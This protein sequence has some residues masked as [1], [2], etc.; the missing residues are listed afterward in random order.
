MMAALERQATGLLRWE[1]TAVQ[2]DHEFGI[3]NPATVWPEQAIEATLRQQDLSRDAPITLTAEYERRILAS[4]DR[5][6]G[7]AAWGAQ[8]AGR[9]AVAVDPGQFVEQLFPAVL[10]LLNT[11]AAT[12]AAYVSGQASLPDSGHHWYSDQN[13]LSVSWQLGF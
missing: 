10:G 1:G 4:M 6:G 7:R 11:V 2:A 8:P 12:P 13:R 5:L 9:G 3:T